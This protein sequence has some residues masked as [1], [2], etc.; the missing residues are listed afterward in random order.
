MQSLIWIGAIVTLSGLAGVVWTLVQVLGARRRGASPEA[1]QEVVK[2]V[3]PVNLG[4]FFLSFIGL[5]LVV[6][7]LIL[8]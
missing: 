8:R 5:M 6:V 3:A 4:A 1:L 7:G 2:K